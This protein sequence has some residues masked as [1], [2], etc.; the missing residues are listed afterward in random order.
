MRVLGIVGSP[1]IGGNTDILVDQVLAGAEEAGVSVEKVILN[2]L[3]INPCQACNSCYKTGQCVQKDDMIPL[4][5]KM[6]LSQLWVLGTPI[7]WWGPTAQ[8]KAFLDRWYCPKH[9][10]FKGKGVIL[11]IPLGGGHERYARHT[12]GLLT[13]VLNY[14][15]M[16]LVDTVLAPG[17]NR[18]GE[19]KNNSNL[20]KKAYNAGKN[21]IKKIN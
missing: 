2:K 5:D 17:F 8:F 6:E 4:L 1:R 9:Q 7:Y 3:D 15:N 19:V 21:A 12:V 20:L 10:E 13:D 16:E 14:L 11:V 18:R